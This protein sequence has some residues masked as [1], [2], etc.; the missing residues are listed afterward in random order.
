MN[1]A[2][3]VLTF[4][5]STK[6]LS[7]AK[8]DEIKEAIPVVVDPLPVAYTK[9]QY[10]SLMAA[11]TNERHRLYFQTLLMTGMRE[12]AK[13]T[14]AH[15]RIAANITKRWAEKAANHKAAIEH[16]QQD[17]ANREIVDALTRGK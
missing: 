8:I 15:K 12:R 14:R 3:S 5:R 13:Y 16:Y 10:E 1:Y 11:I 2:G 4:L 6:V 17:P 9:T 7:L